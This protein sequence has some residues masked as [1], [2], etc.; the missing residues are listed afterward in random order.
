M[1]AYEKITVALPAEL[2]AELRQ[3]V[4]DGQYITQ[5]DIVHEALR[6]WSRLQQAEKR[7]VE[8]LRQ[9]IDEGD[10]SGPSI[11]AEQ[12]YAELRARIAA[13]DRDQ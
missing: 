4:D 7:K 3:S 9:L 13:H 6:D 11:P 1:G 12:V 5:S 2:A 10:R 8:R